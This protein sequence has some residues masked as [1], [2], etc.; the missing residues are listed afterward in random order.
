MLACCA[1]QPAVRRAVPSL[2][3]EQRSCE[4]QAA[5]A[6]CKQLAS[7]IRQRK[8][9]SMLQR[10][11]WPWGG[12]VCCAVTCD[13][14]AADNP[15]ATLAAARAI[16]MLHRHDICMLLPGYSTP[17]GTDELRSAVTACGARHMG[18]SPAAP[19]CVPSCVLK[20]VTASLLTWPA[21]VARLNL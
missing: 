13:D 19:Y 2:Y 16:G 18:C 20:H 21:T 4:P 10:H 6:G 5:A 17:S 12:L 1:Q 3:Q 8:S 7:A 11:A 14:P 15:H 9:R